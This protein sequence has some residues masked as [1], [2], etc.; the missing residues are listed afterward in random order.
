M[1]RISRKKTSNFSLMLRL[2]NISKSFSGVKALQDVSIKF[3]A[4]EVHALCGENGAG[5]STLMNIV[6][7]NLK[8][9]AGK[10]YWNNKEVAIE[11][12]QSAQALGISIVHQERSLVD[13]LSVAE[14]IFPVNQP[15]N[16]FGFISYPQLYK[17]TQH[18]LDELQLNNISP[19]TQIDKLSSAQKQMVEIAKALAQN[20]SLLTLD[21]PTASITNLET[22]TLFSIIKR[23][24]EKGV[25]IIY[26]S[27]RMAEIKTVA[28]VVSVLKDGCYQGTFNVDTT[29]IEQIVTK[30][31]G[32]ELLEAQYQSHKQNDI[33]LEVKNLS[34]KAFSEISFTLHRGEI[35]GI[36]GLQGS[37]RTELVLAIFGDVKISSGKLFKGSVIIH[38]QHPSEAIAYGIAY[39]PDERKP[40]G[41]FMGRSV[42]ENIIS[43]QLT[44]GFYDRKKNNLISEDLKN[45]L[46]IRAPSVKQVV[47][48]LS[49]G[50]QQKVVLA[51]WLYNNPDVLIINEPT[52]GVDVGAKAEIYNELKKLTAEGKSILL[53][54]SEL[55]E[56]LLLSDRIAVM[57]NGS[58]KGILQHDEATEERITAMASG[59]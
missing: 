37:G 26:I 56:L 4:G 28:D 12:V 57:Y 48:K 55:P 46:N 29:P 59:M 33:A 49:G 31:V 25:A 5:K 9:D 14:N 34:G 51:K 7:G 43:A 11:N 8:P 52:H 35:L 38:P 24:K 54:S 15:L 47:Q 27:H 1:L 2:F 45:K 3:N 39:I 44:N 22:Q 32:R 10:I 20:P 19:K 41:L 16:N 18:L 21:E 13:S 23:L 36:A 50:N 17:Q 30:M 6:A 40:Q 58:M 42:T 53:I